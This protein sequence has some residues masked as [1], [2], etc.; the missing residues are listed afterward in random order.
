M[1]LTC[2]MV[3][4]PGAAEQRRADAAELPPAKADHHLH[5]QSPNVTAELRRRL[6][7]NPEH[8]AIFDPALMQ[9]RSGPD[10]LTVLGRAGIAQGALL[11]MAYIFA[12]PRA[13]VATSDAPGLTRVE[14]E[15]NVDAAK[16]SGGRLKAFIS[17]NPFSSFAIDEL[18]YWNGRQSVTG[19]KLHLSNSDFDWHS[20]Q[21]VDQLAQVFAMARDQGMPIIV[22]A[23][24]GGDYAAAE[25]RRFIEQVIAQAGDLP[26]Q[27]AHGGGGGGLD[28]ATLDA[29]ALY[30]D[31]IE[32][33]APGT[34][35]MVFDLAAVLVRDSAEP[36]SVSMLRQLAE[37]MRE[38]G[39]ERFL[40]ASDWPSVLPPREHN[41]WLATQIPLKRD[42]WEVI[43]SNRASYFR[44][45]TSNQS[46]RSSSENHG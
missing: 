35:N 14:N 17:V 43:L 23:R 30:G 13:T 24:A 29:L 34:S 42:E 10:A 8:F 6:A 7:L 39:L 21:Q 45:P 2:S 27:I 28:D 22:H 40:M 15:W 31:A 18:Q 4:L 11:S 19:L 36:H 44:P 33:Q 41:E 12:S 1:C 32:R 38:I 26:V 37:R 5:I 16:A 9:T 20:D 3:V 25:T 46:S